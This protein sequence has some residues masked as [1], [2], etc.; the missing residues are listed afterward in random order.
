MNK[1]LWTTMLSTA[2]VAGAACK[3]DASGKLE[4]AQKNLREQTGDLVAKQREMGKEVQRDM[5]VAYTEFRLEAR[6]RLER[7]E[8]RIGELERT[9]DADS[10][11]A[12]AKLRT[13]RAALATRL[14]SMSE[15]AEAGWENVKRDT[16]ASLDR[17]E[18][19]IDARL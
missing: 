1:I 2:L 8:L 9:G 7:L 4:S 12:A 14:D 11:A 6:E 5:A 10:R 19:D 16:Q 18:M 15:R 17:L 3:N 13:E